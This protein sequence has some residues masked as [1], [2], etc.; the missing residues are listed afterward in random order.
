MTSYFVVPSDRY[1]MHPALKARA[2][3]AY[4]D[5]MGKKPCK[6]FD[7]GRGQ[8]PFGA[9]CFYAHLLQ[10][11]TEAPVQVPRLVE[12]SDAEGARAALQGMSLGQF[13]PPR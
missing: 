3:T 13:L 6:H 5:G 7:Q 9:S 4:Q 1:V 8:C 2:I 10:D 11:G 12:A